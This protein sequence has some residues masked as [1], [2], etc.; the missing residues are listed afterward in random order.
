MVHR[1]QPD[2]LNH[3]LAGL[4]QK[5]ITGRHII[6]TS[7]QKML[8]QKLQNSWEKAIPLKK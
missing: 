2:L 8:M 3:F 6:L 7:L 1:H 5:Y 4:L